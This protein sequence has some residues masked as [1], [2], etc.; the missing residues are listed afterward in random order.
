[1]IQFILHRPSEDQAGE[2]SEIP[3]LFPP[4]E[5]CR[6]LISGLCCGDS[7]AVSALLEGVGVWS[8]GCVLPGLF[9]SERHFIAFCFSNWGRDFP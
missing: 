2:D 6:R 9:S 1:M 5:G 4:S 7:A 3:Q 8:L